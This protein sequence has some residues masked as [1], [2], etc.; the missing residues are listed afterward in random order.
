MADTGGKLKPC[1]A[2][3][4]WILA[5]SRDWLTPLVNLLHQKM[6]KEQYLHA[7]ETTVQVLQEEG[8]KD[9]T[10]SYMLVYSTGQYCKTPIR[11]FEYQP[12]R[13]GHYP[14]KFLKGFK[15]Y[16]HTDAYA[17]Y[18]K[19]PEITRCFCWAHLR[20]NFVDA[21]PKDIK[22]PEATIP[23]Q[24]I[25]FCNNLFEIEKTLKELSSEERK[26]QRLEQEKPVL[27]AFFG[28]G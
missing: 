15:W 10:D 21:L 3:A 16:L 12:G 28:R 9:T 8:R 11:I 5:S 1:Y 2:M 20:R 24:G 7:D 26:R 13:S 27:D 18:K 19:V 6:L 14:Q 4:N 22:S 17:G 25:E 23:S